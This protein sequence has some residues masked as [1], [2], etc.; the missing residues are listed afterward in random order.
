MVINDTY[1]CKG[2]IEVNTEWVRHLLSIKVPS[3]SKLEG[4]GGRGNDSER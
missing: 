2:A 3:C 1:E 4:I